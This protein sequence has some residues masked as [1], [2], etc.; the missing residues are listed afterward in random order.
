MA[1]VDLSKP[2]LRAQHEREKYDPAI[3]NYMALRKYARANGFEDRLNRILHNAGAGG[4]IELPAEGGM[5]TQADIRAQAPKLATLLPR[6]GQAVEKAR[7]RLRDAI[8]RG[9]RGPKPIVQPKQ[10]QF[11]NKDGQPVHFTLDPDEEADRTLRRFEK[12]VAQ[13][14]NAEAVEAQFLPA[15]RQIRRDMELEG[16]PKETAAPKATLHAIQ[17]LCDTWATRRE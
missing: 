6:L 11:T 10:Y 13:L 14:P 15:F 9:R 5:P 16:W 4:F 12:L 3:R 17:Q 7:Y 1:R 2:K 8:D